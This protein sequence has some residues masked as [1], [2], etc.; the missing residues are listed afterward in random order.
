MFTSVRLSRGSK[1]VP[2]YVIYDYDS[3]GDLDAELRGI[4]DLRLVPGVSL[5]STPPDDEML[6][7]HPHAETL[8]D[9]WSD[10]TDGGGDWQLGGHA[11]NFDDYGDPVAGSAHLEDDDHDRDS[12]PDDWVLLAQW[13]GFPGGIVFWTIRR[14]DLAERRF[15]R[16]EVQMHANP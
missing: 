13:C 11:A 12:H 8:R 6:D 7:R 3:P 4:G 15:D 16:V 14:Q 10:Q 5:P 2:D 1:V 9:V